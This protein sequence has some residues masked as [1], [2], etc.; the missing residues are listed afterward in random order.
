MIAK[1]ITAHQMDVRRGRY[2]VRLRPF[3]AAVETVSKKLNDTS[4][5]TKLRSFVLEHL[6][7]ETQ[8]GHLDTLPK[9]H[10]AGL[11]LL[12]S[13]KGTDSISRDIKDQ[14]AGH[15]KRQ[16]IWIIL[17][18]DAFTWGTDCPLLVK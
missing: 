6:G 3:D 10:G 11:I 1:A 12:V 14:L 13:A 2:E 15:P 5:P 16:V 7:T 18:Q 9:A 17:E 8:P 4:S